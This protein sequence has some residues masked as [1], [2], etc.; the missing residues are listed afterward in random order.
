[1]ITLEDVQNIAIECS[2]RYTYDGK[3]VPR[4][5]E[6]IQKMIH[7]EHL[8]QWANSQGFK[9]IYWKKILNEAADIGSKSHEAIELFL[10]NQELTNESKSLFTF[11]S[12]CLWW[13]KLISNNQVEIL[14]QEKKLVCP[15][16]GGTYDL[17]VKINGVIYLVDFK[18][19]NYVTY[20]YYLQL[21]AYNYMLK[22]SGINIGGVIILQLAKTELKYTEYVL[23]LSDPIQK[24]YF[25]LCEQTFLSLVYGYYHITYLEARFNG[26]PKSDN[27]FGTQSV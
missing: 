19:S 9:H 17:L 16:F 8:V 12:F 21:A 7:E 22:M 18:T 10:K 14:G 23:Q 26:L 24:E 2:N 20:K 1:M 27:K 11:Q 4:V 25:D 6:I 15:Y 5:T 13:N 3:N